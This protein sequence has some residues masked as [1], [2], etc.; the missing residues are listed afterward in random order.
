VVYALL[1]TKPL[2][3][4]MNNFRLALVLCAVFTGLA[5]AQVEP[6]NDFLPEK[7]WVVIPVASQHINPPA[8]P[9]LNQKNFGLGAEYRFS[10]ATALAAG[11]FLKQ[12]LQTFRVCRRLVHTV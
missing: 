7:I 8:T 12:Q 9:T 5:H 10:D 6:N 4:M 1:I 3:A 2:N 11:F